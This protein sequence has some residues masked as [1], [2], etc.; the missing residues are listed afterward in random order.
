VGRVFLDGLLRGRRDPGTIL[1]LLRLAAKFRS[2]DER[3]GLRPGILQLVGAMI[4]GARPRP[5][6]PEIRS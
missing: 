5:A 4:G 3:F 2:M 1:R 6:A